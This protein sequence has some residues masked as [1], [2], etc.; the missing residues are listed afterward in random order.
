[1]A[2]DLALNVGADKAERQ[3][4]LARAVSRAQENAEKANTH[5]AAKNDA[6]EPAQT[7]REEDE[8]APTEAENAEMGEGGEGGAGGEGVAE[9]D[10]KKNAKVGRNDPCSC[11]SGKKSK[12]CCN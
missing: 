9:P 2:D 3:E 6:E 8:V 4:A 5:A 11:G 10:N 1:M 7:K 12:K